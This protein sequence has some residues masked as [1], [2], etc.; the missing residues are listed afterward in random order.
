MWS[1]LGTDY[2]LVENIVDLSGWGSEIVN[3]NAENKKTDKNYFICW[4]TANIWKR[5]IKSLWMDPLSRVHILWDYVTLT[6]DNV[7]LEAS[8]IC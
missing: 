4:T 2:F 1:Y 6:D 7:L 3:A 5:N 8:N